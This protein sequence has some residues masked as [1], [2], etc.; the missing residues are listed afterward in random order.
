M[1]DLGERV[2]KDRELGSADR[3]K[4]IELSEVSHSPRRLKLAT[5][6]D[7]EKVNLRSG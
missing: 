3:G 1:V 6:S 4:P 2:S 7:A 5:W